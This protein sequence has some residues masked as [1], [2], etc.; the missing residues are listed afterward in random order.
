[1][2]TL[3]EL[4][5]HQ[6]GH[7]VHVGGVKLEGEG[8]GADVVDCGH[9][10]LHDESCPHG[11]IHT[12]LLWHPVLVWVEVLVTY[13]KVSVSLAFH[14][15]YTDEKKTKYNITEIAESAPK[16]LQLP[17]WFGASVVQKAKILVPGQV[18]LLVGV[19]HHLHRG[20]GVVDAD[21]QNTLPVHLRL[22]VLGLPVFQPL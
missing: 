17:K 22:F 21:D 12:V 14:P 3:E 8:G 7:E 9:H 18:V 4:D 15:D 6:D 5:E 16:V 1:M 13:L 2:T 11:V 19:E 10:P 20:D